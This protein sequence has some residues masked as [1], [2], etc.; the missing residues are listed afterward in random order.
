MQSTS[1]R[2]ILLLFFYS[3]NVLNAIELSSTLLFYQSTLKPFIRTSVHLYAS[4][5]IKNSLLIVYE[6]PK[7]SHENNYKKILKT[8]TSFSSK[9]YCFFPE[10]YLKKA[11]SIY[12][13]CPRI[14][15]INCFFLDSVRLLSCFS[16][17]ISIKTREGSCPMTFRISLIS[18]NVCH[19][20][21]FT[22]GE[23]YSSSTVS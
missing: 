20:C 4:F 17:A 6:F 13:N 1:S 3:Q 16:L 23:T 5:E 15:G 8:H 21:R 22:A 9:F 7:S 2:V 14:A 11:S 18:L 10:M 12:D 19:T